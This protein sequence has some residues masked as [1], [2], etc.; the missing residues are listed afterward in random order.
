M[1]IAQE[2][3][4]SIEEVFEFSVLEIQ[5]W[6]AWFKLQQDERKKVMNDVKSRPRSKSRR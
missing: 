4:R 2:L 5:L 3:G 6:S 1:K